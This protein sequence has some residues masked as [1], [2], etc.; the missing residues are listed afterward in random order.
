VASASLAH[1]VNE[2][3]RDRIDRVERQMR[4]M[5]KAKEDVGAIASEE[6]MLKIMANW[7][8]EGAADD[9]EDALAMETGSR[10]PPSMERQ[11]KRFLRHV[12]GDDVDD[13]DIVVESLDMGEDTPYRAAM[14]RMP[15]PREVQARHNK[16]RL[17]ELLG[18]IFGTKSEEKDEKKEE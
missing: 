17:D 8:F 2:N 10:V 1:W 14:I 11:V 5:E 7:N 16:K 12:L 13:D 18:G 4:V 6:D 3:R 15:R 9:V